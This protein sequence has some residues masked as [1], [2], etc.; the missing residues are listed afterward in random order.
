VITSSLV[1]TISTD[2]GGW[3]VVWNA[4][5]TQVTLFHADFAYSQAYTLSVA[6]QD[7]DGFPL[8]PGPAANPWQFVTQP[9]PWFK[10]FLPVIWK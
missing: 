5:A 7:A 10:V 4:Q 3:N 8:V 6:V 9:R 1:Y 2:P